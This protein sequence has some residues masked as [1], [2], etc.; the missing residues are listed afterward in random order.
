MRALL[1]MY[2]IQFCCVFGVILVCCFFFVC[3]FQNHCGV[4]V[5]AAVLLPQATALVLSSATAD[6][7]AFVSHFPRAL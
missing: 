7:V 4:S 3:F 6:T 2:G 1:Y 5:L